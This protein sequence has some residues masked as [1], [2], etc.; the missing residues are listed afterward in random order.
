MVVS[1]R[2]HTYDGTNASGCRRVFGHD[3]RGNFRANS[4]V[5][6]LP[7]EDAENEDWSIRLAVQ[8]FLAVLPPGV[9]FRSGAE[10]GASYIVCR[11]GTIQDAYRQE[12]V[13][14]YGRYTRNQFHGHNY[15]YVIGYAH[16]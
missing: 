13:P 2:D 1:I 8:P 5:A 3:A 7:V 10:D 11:D 16:A 14:A 9:I 15:V 6:F 12:E 4:V